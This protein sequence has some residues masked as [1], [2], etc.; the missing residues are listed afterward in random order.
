MSRKTEEFLYRF[1]REDCW[2][3]IMTIDKGTGFLKELV[4]HACTNTTSSEQPA[5]GKVRSTLRRVSETISRVSA[6][7]H[8]D[9]LQRP[10]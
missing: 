2:E 3:T 6:L 8:D 1:K 10:A 4:S 5:R 9:S 7:E